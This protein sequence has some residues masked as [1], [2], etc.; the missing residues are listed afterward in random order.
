M[1]Y[2]C[3]IV[4]EL[5]F[6]FLNS[7]IKTGQKLAKLQIVAKV[8]RTHKKSRQRDDNP[9]FLW[10]LLP[11]KIDD[12]EAWDQSDHETH[13]QVHTQIDQQSTSNQKG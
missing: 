13:T 3:L 2:I 1:S 5:L 12:K 11:E 4:N 9:D 10:F 6:Y 8:R 7:I